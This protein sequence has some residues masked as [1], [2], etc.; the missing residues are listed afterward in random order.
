M[1]LLLL[2]LIILFNAVYAKSKSLLS[3]KHALEFLE[4]NII[5]LLLLP[6]S[7]LWSSTGAIKQFDESF[8]LSS[9]FK[10]EDGGYKTVTVED[11]SPN[12]KL[13]SATVC[14]GTSGSVSI[15]ANA[16]IGQ[17]AITLTYQY[18]SSVSG[19]CIS[20]TAP[21][22][23][24]NMNYA[25]NNKAITS[26][27]TLQDNDDISSLNGISCNNCWAYRYEYIN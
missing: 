21:F 7:W 4:G 17:P 15:P 3:G 26:P 16:A 8:Q 5:I 13:G 27:I 20:F 9:N 23:A 22:S 25:G 18:S 1:K 24:L 6:S 10:H 14:T 19:A 12:R 11:L 2:I